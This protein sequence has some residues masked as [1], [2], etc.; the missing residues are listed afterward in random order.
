MNNDATIIVRLPQK[1]RD[2]IEKKAKKKGLTISQY[3][4][5]VILKG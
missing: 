4:R 2:R 1:D 3:M 5:T